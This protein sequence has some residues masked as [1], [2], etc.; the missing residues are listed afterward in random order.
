LILNRC[1]ADSRHGFW[2]AAWPAMAR[3]PADPARILALHKEQARN[4]HLRVMEIEPGILVGKGVNKN[5]RVC[6][7]RVIPVSAELRV[8]AERQH[9]A[10]S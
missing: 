10:L 7:A 3:H 9:L 5:C 4:W 8:E 2:S 1:A 6:G